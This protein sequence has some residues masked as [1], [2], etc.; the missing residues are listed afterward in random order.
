MFPGFFIGTLFLF[1]LV[2][3]A[4][5][6]HRRYGFRRGWGYGP[7][8]V[9]YAGE[10]TEWLWGDDPWDDPPRRQPSFERREAPAG[11]RVEEAIRNVLQSLRDK[12]GASAEQER[13]FATAIDRLRE[14]TGDLQGRMSDARDDLARAVMAEGFDETAFD[15]AS[16]RLDEGVRAMRSA[17]R[18]AL[19][20][21]HD[22][23]DSHQRELLARLIA[24]R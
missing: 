16:S 11:G 6:G 7:W 1:M 14:A 15:A 23:L 21:V 9:P 18:E 24:T 8:A 13:A 22:V 19:G 5:G 12:L 20:H 3:A 17:L 4:F 2:R 10:R